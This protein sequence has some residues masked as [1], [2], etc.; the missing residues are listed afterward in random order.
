MHREARPRP[1]ASDGRPRDSG[2]V[3]LAAVHRV[4]TQ[5]EA[6]EWL[7]LHR[8]SAVLVERAGRARAAV[9]QC[10]CGCGDTISV[11]LDPAVGPAWS[12][13]VREEGLTLMPSVWRTGGCRSHFVLWENRVWWCRM[14]WEDLADLDAESVHAA[15]SDADSD[16]RWP[17]A[18]VEELAE[19]WRR[20]RRAIGRGRGSGD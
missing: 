2:P 18:L 10:P 5:G 14:S 4:S 12:W 8:S 17:R 15:L 7:R 3:A 20:L 19:A 16:D 6:R 1:D 13:R 11:N 9:L